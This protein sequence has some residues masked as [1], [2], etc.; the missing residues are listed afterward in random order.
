MT[1]AEFLAQLEAC[2]FDDPAVSKLITSTYTN[3]MFNDKVMER[4]LQSPLGAQNY[5]S[6]FFGTEEWPDGQGNDF[7]NEYST[8][9]YIP[10][11]FSQFQRDVQICDPNLGNNCDFDLCEVPEGGRGTLPPMR[12]FKWG[13][14][15]RP[16]CIANIRHIRAFRYW[17]AKVIRNREL[18]DEQVMNMFYIMAAINTTGHKITLN[19]V[20]T[21]GNLQLVGSSNPRNPLHAG[22]YNYMEE[23]FPQVTN[24]NDLMPLSIEILTRL[25]RQ[26]TQFPTGNNV[27]TGKRAEPIWEFWTADDWF[28]DE[29]IRNPEYIDSIRRSQPWDQFYGITNQPGDREVMGN[30]APKVMPWLP[31]FAPTS[32]GRIVAVQSHEAV[33]IE[34]GSEFVPS[35]DFENAPIGIASIVSGKQGV[36]LTRPSLTTSGAGFPIKPIS[37]TEPWQINNHYDKECN[38]FENKPFSYR[39]FNMGFQMRDPNAALSFLYRRRIFNMQPVNDC[40]L[41][42]I[43]TV[44]PTV[45]DCAFTTIGCQDGKERVD[46]GITDTSE[47]QFVR[48][49]AASCGNGVSAPFL[50]NITVDRKVNN[51]DFNSLSCDCGDAVT[52][53]I[54]GDEG[55]PLRQVQGVIRDNIK[56]FPYGTYTVSLS[57]ALGAGEC[58]KGILCSDSTP[59]QANVFSAFDINTPGWE[60]SGIV[61]VGMILEGPIGCQNIGDDV[62]VR[63]Y[64]AS[65]IVVGSVNAEI[66]EVDIETN[67]YRFTSVS[68]NLKAQG[69]FAGQAAI[70]VSCNQSPNVSSS[71]SGT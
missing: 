25:A 20:R 1:N 69:A 3:V 13:F 18:I 24:P 39:R 62:I 56:G 9:P 51:V 37:S 66:A 70:G 4:Q 63:Y 33:A 40:D 28:G 15:T 12:F 10:F 8:D 14:Q 67:R 50:Y 19:G 23:L 71:S 31:R 17:A 55:Q 11:S 44:E 57:T 61:G 60:G 42:P 5:Y 16:D 48:C 6:A 7:I 27:A 32:D 29:Y 41:A 53:F 22:S 21:N 35:V 2:N 26:W 38:K 34:V 47:Y 49:S 65:G 64:N 46:D 45:R 54:F 52:L 30:W 43:F 58:I 36:I 59:L 68:P